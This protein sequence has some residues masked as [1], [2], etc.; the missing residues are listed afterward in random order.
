MNL[1]RASAS[2]RRWPTAS[3]SLAFRELL[4]GVRI[5]TRGMSMVPC[6]RKCPSN[7]FENQLPG[8]CAK[9]G[10]QLFESP[11]EAGLKDPG[12]GL[13][14]PES[15]RRPASVIRTRVTAVGRPPASMRS[16]RTVARPALISPISSLMVTPCASRMFRNPGAE[17]RPRATIRRPT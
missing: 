5:A 3:R 4:I 11:A 12:H 10:R 13:A 7:G 14:R 17:S 9:G 16:L 1:L 2:A 8:C 15:S 6:D